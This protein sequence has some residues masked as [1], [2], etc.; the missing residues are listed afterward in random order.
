MNARIS[1]ITREA[2]QS[3]RV[4]LESTNGASLKSFLFKV[5]Q[6]EI[7]VVTSPD[8]FVLYMAYNLGPASALLEAVLAFHYAQNLT[9]PD[10]EPNSVT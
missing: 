2:L 9:L 4:S 6:G 10:P 7:D 8:D 1:S 3:Y 5:Q